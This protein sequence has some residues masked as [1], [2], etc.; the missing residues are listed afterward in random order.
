[1]REGMAGLVRDGTRKP[2]LQPLPP[3]VVDRVVALTLGDP[4]GETTHWTGRAM[5]AA[6]AIAHLVAASGRRTAST[7][8]GAALRSCPPI[9]RSRPS[10]ATWSALSISIRRRTVWC[11]RSTRSPVCGWPP[12]RRR[13]KLAMWH[14][15]VALRSCVRPVD[16]G[17]RM[18]AGPDGFRGLGPHQILGILSLDFSRLFPVRRHNRLPHPHSFPRKRQRQAGSA[19]AGT[20]A[21]ALPLR[22]HGPNDACHLVGQSN[23]DHEAGSSG[24]QALDP[25]IGPGCLRAQQDGLSAD[26]QQLTDV[27]VAEPTDPASLCLPPVD[28]AA[29]RAAR[30]RTPAHRGR[31]RGQARWRR[32]RWRSAARCLGW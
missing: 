28:L 5:A 17:R 23:G 11:S 16:R 32:W 24:Q 30:P 25:R 4:R 18:T 20:A 15:Q 2:G 13:E 21:I 12:A 22:H 29:A 7:A 19:Y 26:D 10:C 9:R 8:P 31:R 6:V 1:M 27:L 14:N 3:A